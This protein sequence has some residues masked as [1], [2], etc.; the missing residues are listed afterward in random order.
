[1]PVPTDANGG[2]PLNGWRIAAWAA[3]AVVLLIPLA[4]MPFTD[5]IAWTAADFAVA[6]AVLFGALG[7]YEVAARTTAS[8]AYRAGAG[9]GIAAAALLLMAN[10]AVGITDGDADALYLGVVAIGVVGALVARFRP[11]GMAVA[12]VVTAL[13]QAA[14]GVIA[15]IAG[16]V[17]DFNPAYEVLGLT[18]FF[19]LLFAGSALLFRKAAAAEPNA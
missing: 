1:M 9:L 16:M 4:A 14:V 12:M 19:A 8:T 6:G 10:G 11:R 7:A 18:G 17:P 15:L 2:R 3:A 13:A 5:E